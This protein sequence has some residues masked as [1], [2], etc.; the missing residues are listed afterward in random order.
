MN[1]LSEM[2]HNEETEKRNTAEADSNDRK[3]L[4]YNF[5]QNKYAK[6]DQYK[7]IVSKI[8]SHPLLKTGEQRKAVM[9]ILSEGGADNVEVAIAIAMGEDNSRVGD[10]YPKRSR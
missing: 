6:T 4:A 8:E 9:K 7:A 10:A 3:R 1:P 5:W 2:W